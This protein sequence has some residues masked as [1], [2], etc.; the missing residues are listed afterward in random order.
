MIGNCM[1]LH[2]YLS[3]FLGKSDCFRDINSYLIK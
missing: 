2:T 3:N 1:Q